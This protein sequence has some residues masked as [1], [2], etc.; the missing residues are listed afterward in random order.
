[1]WNNYS[2]HGFGQIRELKISPFQQ[3]INTH[4]IALN[5]VDI[6]YNTPVMLAT[7]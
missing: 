1:L 3:S 7:N 4:N 5:P 6:N 2:E